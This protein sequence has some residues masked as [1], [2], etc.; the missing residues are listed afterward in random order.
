MK[1]LAITLTALAV[2]VGSAYAADKKKT[3]FDALDKNNDGY[4]TR[5]EAAGNPRLLKG[6]DVADKNNDGKLSR[7]EYLA[8]TTKRKVKD[9]F[10]KESDADPG[11]NALDKNNDG[12]LSRA[13]AKGNP[14][15][16]KQ[17]DKA[18]TN[19]DG[20]LNRAEYLTAMAKKDVKTGAAKVEHAVD[21]NA[22]TGS[23]KK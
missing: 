11:F 6:F 20:K 19:N 22:A 16:A 14:Y 15:L 17:F 13:E 4:L 7:S 18:D 8:A 9:A 12:Y 21:R 10:H 5:T 23:S 3:G 2:A 1:G